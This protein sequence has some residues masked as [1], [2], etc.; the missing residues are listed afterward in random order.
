MNVIFIFLIFN[1]YTLTTQTMIFYGDV[2]VKTHL[3]KLC[4]KNLL[5]RPNLV[6][7]ETKPHL[8][9]LLLRTMNCKHFYYLKN[10]ISSSALQN[11]LNHLYKK[12]QNSNKFQFIFNL[13]WNIVDF[14]QFSSTMLALSKLQLSCHHCLPHI[15]QFDTKLPVLLQW[16]KKILPSLDAHFYA[17]IF[18]FV[19]ARVLHIRPTIFGCIQHDGIFVPK[20]DNDFIKLKTSY[21]YCNLQ[22]ANLNVSVNHVCQC[23]ICKIFNNFKTSLSF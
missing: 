8:T 1:F 17:S 10:F 23:F 5:N 14:G 22:N 11:I 21:R 20:S 18:S 2:S 13:N 16:T 4:S 7:V 6:I 19:D 12:T 3:L 9:K 15:I